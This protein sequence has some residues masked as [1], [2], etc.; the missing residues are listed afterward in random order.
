LLEKKIE[1]IWK[2]ESEMKVKGVDKF[3]KMGSFNDVRSME[4]VTTLDMT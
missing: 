3:Y 4:K 2:S 1:V